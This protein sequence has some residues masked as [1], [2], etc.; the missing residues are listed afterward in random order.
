MQQLG[1]YH[2]VLCITHLHQVAVQANQ[3][4]T[5]SKSDIAGQ[6]LTE[7]NNLNDQTRVEEIARM[8]GGAK[9]PTWLE[10]AHRLLKDGPK[11]VT[12]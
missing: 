2:Q 5:V 6:T 7:I 12:I 4:L 10:Q 1:E 8:L 3:Q 9:D 11:S